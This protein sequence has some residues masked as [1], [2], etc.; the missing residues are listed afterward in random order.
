MLRIGVGVAPGEKQPFSVRCPQCESA[1]RGQLI[2]TEDADVSAQLEEGELLPG[3]ASEDWQV[4]TTHPAFPFVPNTETSPFLDIT[5]VLG[6]ASMPYF[7]AVGEFEGMAQ[8]W[9]KLERAY[10]FYLAENWSRFD[11]AMSRLLEENWPEAPD[12]L[13]RHDLIH[14]LLTIMILPLDPSGVYA[15]MQKEIWQ[16]AQPSGELIA[17]VRQSSVQ[18]RFVALSEAT[19]PCSSA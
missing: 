7:Q 6:D 13:V 16:R 4:I 9:S 8:D 10:Q 18:A 19:V 1:I 3:S 14:R 15:D 12:M 17:Y 2:T 11:A 5:M